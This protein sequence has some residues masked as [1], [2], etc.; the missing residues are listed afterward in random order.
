[1]TGSDW[2]VIDA[3]TIG[4][5]GA[6]LF[7]G[8]EGPTPDAGLFLIANCRISASVGRILGGVPAIPTKVLIK[9]PD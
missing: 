4:A 8:R 3:S 2:S 5:V 7:G 1:M 6:G 9:E